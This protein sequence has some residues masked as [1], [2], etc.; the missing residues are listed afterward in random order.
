M[1]EF[2]GTAPYYA[3]YRP[4]IP[5]A[6]VHLLSQ[7][8][9][10]K[11]NPILLDL[12]S[13]TGQVPAAL[14]TAFAEIDVV[15]RDPG[16]LGEADKALA[17]LPATTVRL[18]N[19]QAED[20]IPPYADWAADMVTIC[21]AFHWM[22]Q[23]AV[24][25]LLEGCTVKD[26]TIAVMGDGSLWTARSA[27]TDA[28]RSMIQEYTGSERRAGKD[29]TYAAHDRPY[30]DILIESAFADVEEH[31][32]PIKRPWTPQTVIGYLYSTSFAA[33]PLFGNQLEEFQERALALLTEHADAGVLIEHA[34]FDVLLARRP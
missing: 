4:G 33:R 22:D 25:S 27:W 12:G 32:I 31:T 34:R 5:E 21:R 28:L 8:V 16:M 29:K 6:S 7:A 24:L 18:H 14:H 30:R 17:G 2:A 10:G 15:E 20:F 11:Q 9:A 26:A 1:S 19:R 3:A 23:P 13:G